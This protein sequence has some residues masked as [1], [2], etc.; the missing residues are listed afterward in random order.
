[1][2]I[3][4]IDVNSRTEATF[5]VTLTV[6]IL[7]FVLVTFRLISRVWIV[8]RVS[9]EDY[10]IIAAWVGDILPHGSFEIAFTDSCGIAY[11]FGVVDCD[12]FWCVQSNS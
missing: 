7:S 2:A 10:L 1:M 6:T 5:A 11:W 3:E 4:N 8:R 9:L 12:S